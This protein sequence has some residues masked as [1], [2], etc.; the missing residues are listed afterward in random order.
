MCAKASTF[1]N[2]L[3]NCHL[4]LSIAADTCYMMGML[5]DALCDGSCWK[6]LYVLI[7]ISLMLMKQEQLSSPLSLE[8]LTACSRQLSQVTG[9]IFESRHSEPQN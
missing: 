9:L 6:A 7:C 2:F 1:F 4:F 5:Y 3:L 8:R